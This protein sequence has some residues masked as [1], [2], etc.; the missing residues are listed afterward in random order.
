MEF[1]FTRSWHQKPRLEDRQEYVEE[2]RT[3]KKK[4]LKVVPTDELI[5]GKINNS[6]IAD[7]EIEKSQ[8]VEKQ[9]KTEQIDEWKKWSAASEDDE[10]ENTPDHAI[11][12]KVVAAL[13]AK[14]KLFQLTQV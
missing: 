12:E 3:T 10:S 1:I 11:V 8:S 13:N 7:Q 2:Q 4:L 9:T 6:S 5:S 14:Q